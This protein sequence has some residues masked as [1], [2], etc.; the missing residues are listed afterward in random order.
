[1]AEPQQLQSALRNQGRLLGETCRRVDALTES[2]NS[3]AQQQAGQLAQLIQIS[4]SLGDLTERLTLLTAPPTAGA[5]S[6]TTAPVPAPAV[7]G[8][9]PVSKPEKYDGAPSQCQGFLL[10]CSL[11]FSNSPPS[12]DSAR[13]SFVV[14]RLT[15]RAL[16]WATAVW[17]SY[18]Q[19]T[20]E[21]FIQDFSEVFDHPNEGRSSGELL[22]RMRQ[23]IRP[24]AE[25]A[26][27]FR[28][29]AAGSGWNEPALVVAFR[30]G[31]HPDL[32]KELACRDDGLDLDKLIALAIRLDQLKRGAVQSARRA[33]SARS[34]QLA[35][36]WSVGALPRPTS[37]VSGNSVPE[38]PMQ[39]DSARLTPAERRMVAKSMQIPVTLRYRGLSL[40]FPA[41]IESGAEG[42]FIPTRVA[43]QLSI[44]VVTLN[45]SLRLSAVDGD[46]VGRGV[47]SFI[48]PSVTM[49]VS[50]LHSEEIRFFVLDSSEYA[51]ILG[52]PWLKMHNPVVSWADREL[53]TW[54]SHCFN[55][56]LMFPQISLS[57][58]SI[59][60]PDSPTPVCIPPEYC[61]SEVFSKSK[62]T[63][64]PPHRSYDCGIELLENTTVPK[65]RV[66]PLTQ[67][68]EIAM[69]EYTREALAQGF[70]RRSTSPAAAGFFFVKKKD[71]GLRPC[72]DYRGLNAISRPYSF[73]L[74]LVPVALEQLRGAVVFTK[75]DLRS[76]YNLIR[77]K[78]GDEWKTAFLTTRGHYEYTVMPYGLRNAPSVFQAFIND[79]LRDMIAVKLAF[80]EWQHWLE[81]AQHPFLVL[82]DHKNLEYLRSAK[83]L[84]SRQARWALF[85]TR[86]NF[87]LTYR[88]GTRNT[89]A[90]ALS[91][92]YEPEAS[93]EP[94]SKTILEPTVFLAP[95]RW[96]IDADI[97]RSNAES[98]VPEG[99]PPAR[100]YVPER[101]RNRLIT[102]AH[103][104]LTTG[105]PGENRTFNLLSGRYWW[106]GMRSDIHR[107]VA[108]C[109]VCSKCKTPRTLPAGKLQPLPVP[110][111]PWSHIAV[112]FVTDLPKSQGM[113][114]ILVVIDRF[115]KGVRFV[116]FAQLPTA[117]QTAECLFHHVFCFFGVPEDIPYLRLPSAE[118][119]PV[120]E[121]P[122][123]QELAKF[124]RVYCHDNQSD[125]ATYLPWAEMAQNSLT[126]STT[127]LTPFQCILGF[128]PPLMPW[129]P[130]SSDVPAV[131]HWMRRSE[132]VWEQTHWR[133]GSVV[134]RQKEQADKHRGSTP[135]YSPGDRVW[136]STRDLRLPGGC[137]KLSP[138]Y[139]GPYRIV[140]KVNDVTYKLA[141]PPQCRMCPTFHVSRFKPVVPGPLD[142]VLPEATPPSPVWFEGVATYAVRK[143]LD[144]RRRSG[145]LQYLVDWEGFGPEEHSWIP[146]SDV[147]D[148]ALIA[149]FHH[150][151]PSRPAPRKGTQGDALA[152]LRGGRRRVA[153]SLDGGGHPANRETRPE[154]TGRP[155]ARG[156]LP[157]GSRGE[158]RSSLRHPPESGSTSA[159]SAAGRPSAPLG[160][161][162]G[163]G[164][165][166][167]PVGLPASAPPNSSS[168]GA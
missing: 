2:V 80:E 14:S 4:D 135:V 158:S 11:F 151:H 71:G 29:V 91:R 81:G 17:R 19:A 161:F 112:D 72:I 118:Q 73:P 69:E 107:F 22:I 117:F 104:S 21:R 86:F 53:V 82:T 75:L 90:D 20:Y 125:W 9:F 65:A 55:H 159:T 27:D 126:S 108:S 123:N 153:S 36:S 61:L 10:Q 70:I 156:R 99:C 63:K 114:V 16:D 168:Q 138:K 137:K 28:I 109:T 83:R 6:A 120:R 84:N 77:I 23:G 102:W 56:C 131:D 160:R 74:P 57:S 79:V 152:C 139:I 48:T 127:S 40:T 164:G 89:K 94:N 30:N 165:A 148:P 103:T 47:V 154:S 130:Q 26:L 35:C 87:R 7:A 92:I 97:E 133:I 88:P 33:S 85:F 78:E 52:L 37:R 132:E 24:V 25:Y 144:S 5:E 115:S 111:R 142:E 41:L 141:L 67:A 149:D 31:L 134:Q 62:A 147:L 12:S 106:E 98:E 100:L 157:P 95:V 38:E 128:Q 13:I 43:K 58:T 50:A 119:R 34:R 155:A 96:E 39:A 116:P 64:L 166:V 110:N 167:T 150:R 3:L 42:N 59:E 68:E 15:G 124:L 101:F 18:G 54:S 49:A 46:P 121:S 113:T 44:P 66:Y 105:H 146:A 51:V 1:M 140:S 163:G 162:G 129:S 32:L 8:S 93:E 60:S 136:L 145:G 45:H 122:A 143:L 76:A